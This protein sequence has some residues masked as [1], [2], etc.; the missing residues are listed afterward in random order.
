MFLAVLPASLALFTF[1]VSAAPAPREITWSGET[2]GPDGPWRAV[3]ALM[4]RD[5]DSISL[6]PGGSW[7][8]WLIE[9][10]YCQRGSCYASKAGTYNR[11]KS[12]DSGGIAMEANLENF[13]LG[14][15]LQGEAGTR[16]MD[17]MSLNG[18][19]VDGTSLAILDSQKIK[20]PGGQTSPFFAGCLSMGGDRTTNQ[21]FTSGG[22]LPAI[23]ASLPPGYLWERGDTPS[24]SFGLHIGSVQ[25]SL[26]GSLWF[27]G[28]DQNRVVGE[29]LTMNGNF[30]DG[31]TLWDIGIDVVG[32]K[33]PFDFDSKDDLLAKGNSS[34]GGGLKVLIDGC[35]PYLTLPRSTCDNIAENLPVHFDE[36]LGLYLWDTDS[37]KYKE[38][39]PSA[40]ALSFSF[41]SESNTDP[42]KIRVPFMH[43]NLTLT[44]PLVD[45]P[46]P[47]FPCHVSGGGH[48]VL[49]R[50]FLQDAF[51][52]ANWDPK[53]NK[54]WLAQAPGRTIQ[55]T[56]RVRTIEPADETISKGGNDWRASWSGVWDDDDAA[57][58]TTTPTPPTPTSEPT[59]KAEEAE[60]GMSTG[61]KA[62]I[63][64]GI[65]V[66]ALATGVGGFFFWRRRQ[67]RDAGGGQKETPPPPATGP[68]YY[69]TSSKWPPSELPVYETPQELQQTSTTY[70]RYELPS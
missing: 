1:I 28:Y 36:G 27:G 68:S 38:I 13:M 3:T 49:G 46:T 24:N 30:R 42:V 6:F 16:W 15:D 17:R 70:Q 53:S 12:G 34:I 40:T 35:S 37:E 21:S 55:A 57:V 4:G 10:K 58:T 59:D 20:Y 8:T 66:V 18:G 52:G 19:T 61:A 5:E 50:A 14:L 9:D 54:W 29:P 39:V 64:A 23:N 63:G 41:I 2:F 60:A 62:G 7:E 45:T 65:G 67:N 69:T 11:S 33:S 22:D 25:P 44:A 56:A 48:Y 51:V 43:L 32:S 26:S 31:I 47:Y